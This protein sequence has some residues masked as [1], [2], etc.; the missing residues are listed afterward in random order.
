VSV[1]VKSLWGGTDVPE[2]GMASR[3][4]TRWDMFVGS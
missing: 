3:D 2:E 4:S 1:L